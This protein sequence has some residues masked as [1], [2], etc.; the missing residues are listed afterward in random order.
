[1]TRI[2]TVP[3][4]VPK[5][6][7]VLFGEL[8]IAAGFIGKPVAVRL[9]ESTA[10]LDCALWKYLAQIGG[11]SRV[12]LVHGKPDVKRMIKFMSQWRVVIVH[13]DRLHNQV[14]WT[15]QM[16]DSEASARPAIFSRAAPTAVDDD[17]IPTLV[18]RG[19]DDESTAITRWLMSASPQRAVL[20]DGQPTNG[21]TLDPALV[22]VTMP[23]HLPNGRGPR[24]LRDCQLLTAL[25]SGASLLRSA[26]QPNAPPRENLPRRESNDIS[27]SDSM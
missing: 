15:V 8:A 6:D 16:H 12:L 27:S 14:A 20:P 1:M 2:N 21:V 26:P 18:L 24:R 22:P 13:A 5:P 25:L 7:S 23:R 9:S 10:T 11:P 3:P 19:N 17:P 4:T